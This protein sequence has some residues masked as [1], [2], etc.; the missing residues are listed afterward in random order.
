MFLLID[1]NPKNGQNKFF[2]LDLL[3]LLI[4]WH[5]YDYSTL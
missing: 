5:L 1:Q 4:S 2:A 3:I